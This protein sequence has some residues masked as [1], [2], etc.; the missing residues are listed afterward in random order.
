[1]KVMISKRCY[2]VFLF[3]NFSWVLD[4]FFKMSKCH[5]QTE[6]RSII[7]QTDFALNYHCLLVPAVIIILQFLSSAQAQELNVYMAAPSEVIFPGSDIS[8][9]VLVTNKGMRSLSDV[10]VEIQLPDY[11][12]IEEHPDL[13]CPSGMGSCGPNE[14][15]IWS[16]GTLAPG[17]SKRVI[18]GGWIWNWV[19]EGL[20]SS[21]ATAKATE[22][23]NVTAELN[24]MIESSPTLQLSVVPE[25]GP[26]IPGDPFSYTLTL[27]NIGDFSPTGVVLTMPV[28]AGTTVSSVSHDGTESEGVVSWNVGTLVRG[29]GRQ[30]RLT[31]KVDAGLQEG[32]VLMAQPEID[33]GVATVDV[34]TASAVTAVGSSSPLQVAY[35]IT[36]NVGEQEPIRYSLTV[37]NSGKDIINDIFI[38]SLWSAKLDQFEQP[39]NWDCP[40]LGICASITGSIALWSV[41]T[42]DP[43]ESRTVIVP[44][45]VNLFNVSPGEVLN[46]MLV[47][48]ATGVE[49]V[50]AAKSIYVDESPLLRLSLA[51][52]PGPILPGEPFTYTLTFGNVGDETPA[53]VVLRMPVPEGTHFKSATDGG[54]ES[55]GMITWD[56]G[57]LPVDK[58]GQVKLNLIVDEDVQDGALLTAQAEIDP[59]SVLESIVESS[60]VSVVRAT[61]PLRVG[62]AVNR[63]ALDVEPAS[64]EYTYTVTVSNASADDLTDVVLQFYPPDSRDWERLYAGSGWTHVSQPGVQP[65][66]YFWKVGRLGPG[67]SQSTHVRLVVGDYSGGRPEGVVL[68]SIVLAEATGSGQVSA[69]QDVHIDDKQVHRLSLAQEPGPVAPSASVTYTLTYGNAGDVPFSDLILRMALPKGTIFESAT[70]NWIESDEVVTWDVGKLDAGTGGSVSLNVKVDADVSE[71]ALLN[72]WAEMTS[73]GSFSAVR[74]SSVTSVQDD[75][76]LQITYTAGDFA[77]EPGEPVTYA[78]TMRNDRTEDLTDVS[79]RVM[80]PQYVEQLSDTGELDC[81]FPPPD[82]HGGGCS[83]RSLVCFWETIILSPGQELNTSFTTSVVN[84]APRGGILRSFATAS[85]TGSNQISLHT[86]AL[87]G[88][89]FLVSNEPKNTDLPKFFSLN[90]NFPNPFNP[91]TV[92][93]FSLPEVTEVNLAVY[94]V[95]GQKVATLIDQPMTAG[96]HRVDFD[97]SNLSS[98][99]YL[100][101]ITAGNFVQTRKLTLIK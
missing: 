20:L 30:Y 35:A 12:S 22:V 36:Q 16:I 1:M 73:N 23:D 93:S 3:L 25:S 62:F 65:S 38:Q 87:I 53:D 101:R 2:P 27:G 61:Q 26:A 55:N 33:T 58:G 17:Q 92:I 60:A 41:E 49:E 80:L 15:A 4:K 13:K 75:V 89:E 39:P 44:T 48:K 11:L 83:N 97:A 45:G 8:Y 50:T 69:A 6:R 19:P 99:V 95:I 64:V 70:G 5:S 21:S 85:A 88:G 52:D 79:V 18:Y 74:S 54:M 37:S 51:P 90:Q 78:L 56:L 77:F 24:V 40:T 57:S 59:N 10:S 46:S 86:D 34:V 84:S 9:T 96:S 63:T 98:G 42:L 72:T 81:P 28:P 68:R 14:I 91:S 67:E 100:Y 29:A 32:E 7:Y 94:N 71:G 43:G 82:C 47:A 66:D 31:L 76:P